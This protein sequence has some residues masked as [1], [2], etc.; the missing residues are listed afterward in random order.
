MRTNTKKSIVLSAV[1][2]CAVAIGASSAAVALGGGAE[3]GKPAPAFELKDQN[4]KTW[5]LSDFAGKT[6]VLEWFNPDCPFIVGTY[7]KG[8]ASSTIEALKKD[9]AVFIAINS[10]GTAPLEEVMKKSTALLE[11]NKIDHPILFDH[12]GT[13][14]RAYGAQTTPHMYVID[15]KGVLRYQGAFSNDPKFAN[16]SNAKNFVLEACQATKSGAA[17][18]STY[19]KPWG[20][21]VKYK[22]SN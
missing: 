8:L 10:T 17:P 16:A 3:V 20:C 15:P 7:E 4:G 1:A 22:T 11:K 2:A 13:V 6:V 19:E 21:N 5:K 12:D 9:G 18:A 14:G